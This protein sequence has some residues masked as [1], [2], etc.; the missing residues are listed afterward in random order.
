[1]K[2]KKLILMFAVLFLLTVSS[3][4]QEVTVKIE[5]LKTEWLS[6]LKGLDCASPRLSWQLV[7]KVNNVTQEAYRIKVAG[8]P[9]ELAS[10]ENLFWDTGKIESD[11][12]HLIS[13]KGSPLKSGQKLY[14]KVKACTNKGITS[15]ND[16][17]SWTMA[18]LREDDWLGAWIGL[19][20]LTHEGEQLKDVVYTRLSAR[21][22]RSFDGSRRSNRSGVGEW[23]ETREAGGGC[24]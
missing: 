22:L 14:W 17:G 23:R 13:Y 21:Y 16:A 3:C 8:S 10:G 7:S 4:N 11:R 18:L 15:W 9:E 24:C 6:N 2:Q 5:N 20:S 19:D 12:S 1:M